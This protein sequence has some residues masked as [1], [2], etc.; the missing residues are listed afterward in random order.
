MTSKEDKNLD[1]EASFAMVGGDCAR[2]ACTSPQWKS[3]LTGCPVATQEVGEIQYFSKNEVGSESRPSAVVLTR[4]IGGHGVT[5]EERR[6][7][8]TVAPIKGDIDVSLLAP[9][10]FDSSPL[11]TMPC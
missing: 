11:K 5:V 3:L 7:K 10:W 4:I 6:E 9:L 2:C 1:S 8:K